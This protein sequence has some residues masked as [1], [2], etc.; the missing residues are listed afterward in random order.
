MKYSKISILLILSPFFWQCKVSSQASN[1][2]LGSASRVEQTVSKA[3]VTKLVLSNSALDGT[4]VTL[5]AAG[6]PEGA[7][8][9]L[10]TVDSSPFKLD[11]TPAASA[12]AVNVSAKDSNGKEIETLSSPMSLSIPATTASL[13]LSEVSKTDENLCVYLE[14]SVTKK[15]IV[16]YSTSFT[17]DSTKNIA[18]VRSNFLGTFQL[19]YCGKESDGFASEFSTGTDPG[20]DTSTGKGNSSSTGTGNS[21]SLSFAVDTS[22][23]SGHET[24]CLFLLD[25]NKSPE[26]GP[27]DKVLATTFGHVTGSVENLT[28]TWSD[29]G[30]SSDNLYLFLIALTKG[31]DSS[32]CQASQT[33][34]AM[35]SH[36]KGYGFFL[37]KARLLAGNANGAFGADNYSLKSVS[38]TIGDPLGLSGAVKIAD[39]NVC[40]YGKVSDVGFFERTVTLS[41]NGLFDGEKNI[42]FSVPYVEGKTVERLE[43]FMGSTCNEK[44]TE[45]KNEIHDNSEIFLKSPVNDVYYMPYLSVD[46]PAELIAGYNSVCLDLFDGN[47]T[48]STRKGASPI[49]ISKLTLDTAFPILIPWDTTKVDAN[50]IPIVQGALIAKNNCFNDSADDTG[51]EIFGFNDISLKELL[52]G[53]KKLLNYLDENGQKKIAS[54]CK[55]MSDSSS[56]AS[57]S[58]SELCK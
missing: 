44:I 33:F 16:W 34:S 6:L 4:A 29:L 24:L 26:D 55:S 18:T 8:I 45:A 36:T 51:I 40:V 7:V 43:V 39:V 2:A 54:V 23:F 21:S 17:F 53:E 20:T 5:P 1:L 10:D 11:K 46:V 56:T 25:Q 58:L 13:N 38:L 15:K 41:A 48:S 9:A 35:P 42:P 37:S 22:L 30:S 50:M 57:L 19:V 27:A 49:F 32:T 31:V 47:M 52:K 3:D 28:L 14:T 12:V